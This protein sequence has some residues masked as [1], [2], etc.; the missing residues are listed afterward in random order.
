MSIW[1]IP[2][3][4]LCRSHLLGEHRE[5]HGVWSALTTGNRD[6]ASSPEARRW[7]GKLAALYDRHERLVDEL[8][9]RGFNHNSPLD[10]RKATGVKVQTEFVFQPRQQLQLLSAKGCD[11]QVSEGL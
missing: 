11:C 5:L 7:Q 10:K 1:D 3:A 4:I 8:T 6:P 2:P 9:A